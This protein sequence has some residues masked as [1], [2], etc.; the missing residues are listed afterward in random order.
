[1]VTPVVVLLGRGGDL[2]M[3]GPCQPVSPEVVLRCNDEHWLGAGGDAVT[4][5]NGSSNVSGAASVGRGRRWATLSVLC[6]TLLLISLDNTILNVALPSVVRALH[7]TSSQLQWIVDAYAVVF[8]GL[9]FT[10]GALGDRV[11]RKW[12]FMGGLF[13]FGAGSALAAWSAT[14]TASLSLGP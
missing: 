14:R 12:V 4:T 8:A 2:V 9:L 13:V 10:F 5:L 11:G 6:V 7:T 1:M 3:Y